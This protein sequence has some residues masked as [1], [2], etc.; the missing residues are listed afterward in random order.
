MQQAFNSN[1]RDYRKSISSVTTDIPQNRNMPGKNILQTDVSFKL[2]TMKSPEITRGTLTSLSIKPSITKNKET[3]NPQTQNSQNRS[4][5]IFESLVPYNTKQFSQTQDISNISKRS[6]DQVQ[7]ELAM[8]QSVRKNAT[9]TKSVINE[10]PGRRS[11]QTKV[12]S[13]QGQVRGLFVQN[14]TNNGW[15]TT[16]NAEYED[17]IKVDKMNTT[18]NLQTVLLTRKKIETA[19]FEMKARIWE[20]NA[21]SCNCNYFR[22]NLESCLTRV[23]ERAVV[24]EK[25]ECAFE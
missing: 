9:Q 4:F 18:E 25:I 6:M 20:I 10:R 13:S 15:E 19:L 7:N 23:F 22:L 3:I 8:T 17:E 21:F 2:L 14:T 24:V 5:Q 16:R 12:E 1:Y 11:H